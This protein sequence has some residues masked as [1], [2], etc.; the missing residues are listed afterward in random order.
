MFG[1]NADGC[2]LPVQCLVVVVIYI[3]GRRYNF[4]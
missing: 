3:P 1:L 4:G 2:R